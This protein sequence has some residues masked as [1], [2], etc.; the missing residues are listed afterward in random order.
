MSKVHLETK[1]NIAPQQPAP[2]EQSLKGVVS[3]PGLKFW[4]FM[5]IIMLLLLLVLALISSNQIAAW[6]TPQ[7]LAISVVSLL[8]VVGLALLITRRIAQRIERIIQAAE[9]VAQGDFKIQIDDQHEDEI[10]RLVRSFNKMVTNLDELQQ[11]RELLSRTISPAVRQLLIERGLDFRGIPQMVSVLFVDMWGFTRITERYNPEQL[12]FFLNDYYTTIA[13]QVHIGDGIIGKYGGDS[14]LAYFGALDPE[15]PSKTASSALL[16]ALALQD[17]IEIMSERWNYLGMPPIRVGIGITI[18]SVMAGPIGSEQQFEYTVIGD[19]VNLA[20]RLQDLTRNVA[21]Y[22][23]MISA[24]LY[25]VLDQTV[26]NQIQVVSAEYYESLSEKERARL[27]VYFV[28]LGEVL[29]KGKA[30]PVQ[31]Y[32]IPDPGH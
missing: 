5:P 21:G 32:A 12:I 13:N 27:P 10:G 28:D 9:Q 6:A 31:V 2:K 15:P 8:G 30:G 20:S 16:T 7:W 1:P 18:G 22:N 24:E 4:I 19:A 23:I 11:T 25:E 26:K 14:I 3:G 17:A 29:V